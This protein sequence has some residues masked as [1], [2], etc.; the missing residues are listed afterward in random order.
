MGGKANAH[1]YGRPPDS[2]DVDDGLLV[3]RFLVGDRAAFDALVRR[4]QDPV[5]RYVTWSIGDGEAEDAAQDVFVEMHRSLATWRRQSTFR[6]WLYGVARNV[7]RRHMR[8]HRAR[9]H[10]HGGTDVDDLPGASD[11]SLCVAQSD[12]NAL[13]LRAI[14][15]LPPDQRVTLMLRAWEGLAYDEIAAATD[16]PVGTVRSRLHTA[17]RTLAAAIAGMHDE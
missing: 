9:G 10:L 6:T 17:R 13:L 5:L 3:D 8:R 14:V 11:P 15:R 4:Y 12:T 7:C 2:C 1:P 16:V